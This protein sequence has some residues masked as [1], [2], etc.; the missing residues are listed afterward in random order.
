[1][2]EKKEDKNFDSASQR[3]KEAL[4]E[5]E[6]IKKSRLEGNNT[7]FNEAKAQKEL[8]IKIKSLIQDLS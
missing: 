6:G 5:F 4:K 2:D 7:S 1:M 3:L 8:V